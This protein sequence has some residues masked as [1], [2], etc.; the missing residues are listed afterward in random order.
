MKK[1]ISRTLTLLLV[2]TVGIFLFLPIQYVYVKPSYKTIEVKRGEMVD[3]VYAMGKVESVTNAYLYF[4]N[5][6]KITSINVRVGDSVKVGDILASQDP[7]DIRSQVTEINA[8]INVQKAR[9]NQLKAGSSQE[10]IDI[11][12]TFV[13]NAT[14]NLSNAE[15]SLKNIKQSGVDSL[16][17]VSTSVD[18]IISNKVD[19]MITNPKSINPKLV[20]MPAS[21]AG[22]G[23]DVEISR[24]SL[25][26]VL[27]DLNTRLDKTD[28][29]GDVAGDIVYAKKQ[30]LLIKQF[31]EKLSLLINNPINK[32]TE[33]AQ[34]VWDQWRN[35]IALARSTVETIYSG[36]TTAQSSI[37]N[38]E[39]AVKAYKG[40]LKNA[41]EQLVLKKT[42][43]RSTDLAV[44]EAQLA[45][46]A[47][48][49]SKVD[50]LQQDLVVISP[51]NGLVSEVNN[52][53]GE[54]SGPG[55]VLLT[56]LSL[57]N[58]QIK[59][60]VVENN[61]TKIK[62]GQSTFITFDA[63]PDKKFEGVVSAIDPA[64][65]EINGTVYYKTTVILNKKEDFIRSGMTANVWVT[66]NVNKDTLFVPV[67]TLIKDQDKTFVKV[68]KNNVVALIEVTT[69]TKDTYGNIEI[70]S[71]L[72][73][74]DKIIID[75]L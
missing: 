4:K 1:N 31:L 57:D 41:N 39:S 56:V 9:I 37:N 38:A 32:P 52:K 53:V 62:L 51:I 60:N 34:M 10:E 8:G 66:V 67:S 18:D 3:E 49:R 35:D 61:I 72:G 73:E 21:D 26:K 2:I 58:L 7:K 68:L 43:T 70:T 40:A 69:G 47:A 13:S 54:L 36:L 11:A 24:I 5:P 16:K 71:G 25:E 59:V 74:G 75:T 12:S 14:L 48:A 44:Y 6:G 33:K 45:Q 63:M 17:N 15:I 29:D 50:A 42:A 28:A 55:K 20:F 30:L 23:S 19:Q 22:L 64:E 46:A 27:E 65:T